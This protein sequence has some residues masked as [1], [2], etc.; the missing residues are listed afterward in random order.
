VKGENYQGPGLYQHFKGGLYFVVGT[1]T[2]A[3]DPAEVLVLYVIRTRG[4]TSYRIW[5][6]SLK[7]FNEYKEHDGQNVPRFRKLQEAIDG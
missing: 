5:A 7:E 3:S 2:L 1:A 4:D 6:R